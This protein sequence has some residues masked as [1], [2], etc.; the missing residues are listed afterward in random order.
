[1]KVIGKT[2]DLRTNTPVLYAQM[3]ISDYLALVG[4]EFDQFEIQRKRE[5]HKAYDRM[6]IDLKKGALL[7]PI[8]LAVKVD[9]VKELLPLIESDE[10]PTQLESVLFEPGHFNILDGLQRTYILKDLQKSHDFSGE[11]RLLVEF[12]L[13]SDVRHLI[14]RIIVLNAGQKPMSMRHQIELLFIALRENLSEEISDIEIFQE[15]ETSRRNKPRKFALDRLAMAYQSFLTKSPEIEKQN[16]IAQKLIEEEVLSASEEDLGRQ[17]ALFKQYL[18]TYADMDVEICR[19]YNEPRDV[20]GEIKI[21]SGLTWFGS[22]N[23]MNAFFAALS[24]IAEKH[25]N[26][27]EKALD[28]LLTA[29]KASELNSDP[30]K[31]ETLQKLRLQGINPRKVNIGFATRKLLTTGFKDYFRDE[32]ETDLEEC[33]KTAAD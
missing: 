28:N 16:I 6:R 13:E 27:V 12:W 24:S 19:I 11:Q 8:T 26:R 21:E 3:S 10:N 15:N 4:D 20:E 32:G 17:F 25:P 5:K 2:K 22:E 31:L 23:V 33:W 7:P 1:M 18:Q 14:Y 29:L 9:K 30:L